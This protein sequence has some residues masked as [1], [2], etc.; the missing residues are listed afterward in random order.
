MPDN[1]YSPPR[2]ELSGGPPQ[3]KRGSRLQAVIVGCVV[4][5][6][7]TTLFGVVASFVFGIA[8]ATGGMSGE[9]I[10]RAL[11]ASA[12]FQIFSFVSGM[13]FTVLGGFVAA[14]IANYL[15]YRTALWVGF[16]GLVIGEL[17][18]GMSAQSSYPA[19]SRL[20]GDLLIMPAALFGANLKVKRFGKGQ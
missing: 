20:L 10:A 2:A 16:I 13:A 12:V 1:P 5:F 18:L 14:R 15:E 4:D 19:W 17:I 8:L 9:D 7:G 3:R 6:V 11:N